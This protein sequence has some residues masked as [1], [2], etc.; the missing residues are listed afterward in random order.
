M[1]N[2]GAVR[3]GR[4]FIELFADDSRLVRGLNAASAKLR[5]WGQ[6]VG[7]FGRTL[8]ASG[9][10]LTGAFFGAAKVFSAVG[11][12][13]QKMSLRTG[14][15]VETLSELAFAADSS[16]TSLEAVE[17]AIRTMQKNI[18]GDAA[19]V[20]RSVEKMGLSFDH[21]KSLTPE[22][23]LKALAD[24][25]ARVE[26]PAE[27][28]ALAV[29]LFGKAGASLLPLLA[30]GASGIEALQHQARRLGLTM[31]REDA[32]AAA[33]LNDALG[34][35]TASI[36]RAVVLVG[37]AVAPAFQSM[38]KWITAVV[39]PI[40]AFIDA[41]RELVALALK[42]AAAVAAA[43]AAFMVLGVA[44]SAIGS[45]FSLI[46]TLV[47]GIGALLGA[48]VS[49]A[50]ALLNPLGLVVVLALALGTYALYVS[51]A[52]EPVLKWLGDTFLWLGDIATQAWQGITDAIAAGDLELAAQIAMAGLKIVWY[53]ALAWLKQKWIDFKKSILD[54]WYDA[55]FGLARLFLEAVT[56]IQLIWTSLQSTFR[57]LWVRTIS[58]LGDAWD[59]LYYW[60]AKA[61]TN[62]TH[63]FSSASEAAAARQALDEEQAARAR[64]RRRKLRESLER[65][66][67]DAAD[68]QENLGKGLNDSLRA[69]DEDRKR[70]TEGLY[71]DEEENVKR[72]KEKAEEARKKFNELT[73]EA[74]EAREAAAAPKAA[75]PPGVPKAPGLP[76]DLDTNFEGPRR[77]I[78]VVGTFNALAASGLGASSPMERTARAT[79][80]TAK[81]TKRMVQ[82]LR[83]PVFS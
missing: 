11:D 23:Q 13:L 67:R 21:L 26:D 50:T 78:S 51:G 22:G 14:L 76:P 15:S 62:L 43:G 12:S 64:E 3:A 70:A 39:T 83:P 7:G 73:G 61:F 77:S 10:A 28:A 44:L 8:L 79:E 56:G 19:G 38:A 75:P 52:W 72:L 37:A 54:I 9:G 29:E 27:K 68:K 20:R 47:S 63:L 5:A 74:K 66:D 57:K 4:A 48:M 6:R 53:E 80:E 49:A 40:V 16:G 35:L 41:N 36:K 59:G 81:N 65:I 58:F 60:L 55:V 45:A 34:A 1:A 69:L 2:A 46:A 31:S 42:I 33:T 17:S 32:E 82:N 25:V 24:V 18:A 30:E 71:K